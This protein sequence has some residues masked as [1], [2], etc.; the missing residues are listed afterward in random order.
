MRRSLVGPGAFRPVLFEDLDHS[1][2]C[3]DPSQIDNIEPLGVWSQA[4]G[5]RRPTARFR[6]A[7][8]KEAAVISP[9]ATDKW[10]RRTGTSARPLRIVEEG[11]ICTVVEAMFVCGPSVIVRHYLFGKRDGSFEIRDRIL[12]NHKDQLLKLDVPLGFEPMESIS[13]APYSAVRRQPTRRF[14]ERTNQRW[15]VVRGREGYVAAL[16]NGSCAH[17]LTKSHLCLNILRSPAYASMRVTPGDVWGDNRFLPR[18]DQG[19][20]EVA[21]KFLFGRRFVEREV[22]QVSTAFNAVP[23]YQVFYPDGRSRRGGAL[24]DLAGSIQVDAA[25]VQIAALKKAERGN[26]LIVRLQE[27]GGR[28]TECRVIV[29]GCRQRPRIEIDAYGLKTVRLA[30][31]RGRLVCREVNL[32]EGL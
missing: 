9:L 2:T 25:N 30:R 12:F 26:A 32:V 22:T 1:W 4:P 31:S 16:N 14:E 28:A 21:F 18:H 19:E 29:K 20:H 10:L 8:A 27:V 24:R 11:P 13:E 5:W 6:L 15:V 3:G 17:S 23:Y 7:T